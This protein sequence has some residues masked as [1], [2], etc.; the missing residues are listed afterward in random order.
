MGLPLPSQNDGDGE[1]EIN[2]KQDFFHEI[3]CH[4]CL[5]W[6]TENSGFLGHINDHNLDLNGIGIKS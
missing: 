3:C 5:N 2:L 4:S 1:E 6:K